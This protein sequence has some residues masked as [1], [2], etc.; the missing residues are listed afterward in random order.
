M[1]MAKSSP[2]VF[3]VFLLL[4]LVL[5]APG[6]GSGLQDQVPALGPRSEAPLSLPFGLLSPQEVCGFEA[7]FQYIW[8]FLASLYTEGN[9]QPAGPGMQNVT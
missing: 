1:L 8:S 3:R 2:A 9:T 7:S 6:A 5:S 4:L